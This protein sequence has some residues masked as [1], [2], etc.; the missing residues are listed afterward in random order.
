MKI[1]DFSWSLYFDVELDA[2]S[3]PDA[4]DSAVAIYGRVVCAWT[5]L[6]AV[7]ERPRTDDYSIDCYYRIGYVFVCSSLTVARSRSLVT[8]LFVNRGK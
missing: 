8:R 6:D 2:H 4:Y 1:I 7:G 3:G 5:L